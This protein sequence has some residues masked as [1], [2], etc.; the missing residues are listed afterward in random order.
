MMFHRLVWY[1]AFDF[2]GLSFARLSL[3]VFALGYT[4]PWIGPR[5][6]WADSDGI[7]FFEQKIRPVLIEHCYGCHSANAE[8][9]KGNLYLDSKKGWQKGGDSGEPVIVAGEP[10]SSLLLAS[11][12]H[13]EPGLEMP[14][15]GPKLPDAVIADLTTWIK[16]GAPD[17]RDEVRMEVKRGDKSWWSLQPL[18][19][20]TKHSTIDEFI[21]E[22][23]SEKGLHRNPPADPRSLIRRMTFDVI[24]LPPTM[25]EVDAF[26]KDYQADNR[27]ALEGLVDR[28][29]ASPRY[30]ERWGRHWLD[31][32]RFG[33]SIG[34]E[35]NVIIDNL[36]PFRD[37]VIRS[38]NDDKPF[39]QF[40]LEHLAGDVV[41][42]DDPAVEIGSA[43]LVAGP[44]DDVGNQDVVAQKNI[45]AATLDDMITATSSAFL[46]LTINC[47]R[48]HN[49]KFD[50]I[51][52]EDYYRLRL[53]F[54]GIKHGSRVI[55]SAEERQAFE[56]AMQPLVEEKSKL[57]SIR[58]KLDREIQAR[59]K[60]E[61]DKLTFARPKVDV[62]GTTEEFEPVHARYVRFVVHS[63]TTDGKAKA[64][65]GGRGGRL[66]EFEVF[67]SEGLNV[68]LAS[69]GAT[70]EGARSMVAADFPDAYGPQLCIDGNHGEQWFIGTPA[71]LT[72][73]LA[74]PESVHSIRFSNSKGR[75]LSEDKVRGATPCE[76]EVQVSIDGQQWTKVASSDGREPWS[77]GH[78]IQSARRNAVS[79]EETKTLQKLDRELAQLQSQINRIPTLQQVWAGN[80]SQPTDATFVH[81]GG[82]PMR[83]ST[84]VVPSSL[85]VLDQVA[86]PFA[87]PADAPESQRRLEL[88]KWIVDDTNPLTAR[89]L[90]NRVW[91]YHFGTGIV[92][93][94]SDF[95]F[96]G[97]QPTHPALL[98]YLANQLIAYQW[99]LKPLHREILL[100]DT[101]L[102]SS[103]FDAD[104]SKQ[105]KDSRLLW[106]FPPRRLS[107]EEIRDTI[108]FTAGKL[109]LEPMGGP[110]F[111]LYQFTQNNVCTYFPLNNHGPETY[112]RSVYHQNARASV[113][114]VLNDF[115]L[116]DIAFAA[117]R[118]AN[119]T[120]P[121]QALT[122]LNHSFT[123]DMA[124]SLGQ[125]CSDS[126]SPVDSVV[127]AFRLAFQR[128][129]SEQETKL[130]TAYVSENGLENFCR[131]L[132]NTNEFIYV[133]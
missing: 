114:D 41:G 71:E 94:P 92:D 8:K 120:T 106:R 63:L 61:F 26:A 84:P 91:Q 34:F 119:T 1:T 16:M 83:P 99:R 110:G 23:L 69:H 123:L 112:R 118:R 126:T 93:T 46:G 10:E 70:A 42:K 9:L 48:C 105:D 73:T 50:P 122:L 104:A 121:L 49:H 115:D 14:P 64:P 103:A 35:R 88:A 27:R 57:T 2:C 56:R 20:L 12:Q 68:A 43:F 117:P 6:C 65:V 128:F 125:R 75:D 17:P 30:G 59:A 60:T 44:Y 130:A 132:L 38:I 67:N 116:P 58:E 15:D 85:G 22:K 78:G 77:E 51:P 21:S 45:R 87:L 39:N 102:Q 72:I 62:H 97:S 80:Y 11:V 76:Y 109:K 19:P 100:S 54:E 31:V 95:G 25:E 107:A 101:Y 66:T 29:L 89:V 129:P 131:L 74:K 133:D 108:L 7:A 18:A 32:I 4:V 37:Y 124:R 13:L 36:W 90:A 28:L 79:D 98:D 127:C 53:A 47:A 5:V 113:V 86:K 24:G 111:R 3:A 33:E 52:T 96:L 81:L 40:I 55:A 82:D